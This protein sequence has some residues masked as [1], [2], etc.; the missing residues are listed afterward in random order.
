MLFNKGACRPVKDFREGW[1]RVSSLIAP[2]RFLL[3]PQSR[4]S[5]LGYIPSLLFDISSLLD[6]RLNRKSFW[7]RHLACR[8]KSLILL[9]GAR[10]E[11]RGGISEELWARIHETS[12]HGSLLPADTPPYWISVIDWTLQLI[13]LI[14]YITTSLSGDRLQIKLKC[15]TPKFYILLISWF[16]I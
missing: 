3:A 2:Q 6:P 8:P 16:T 15:I 1:S 5:D 12:L 13:G 14:W 11:E 10:I 7:V 4:I 9:W